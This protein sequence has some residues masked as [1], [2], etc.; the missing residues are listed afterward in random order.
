MGGLG[1]DDKHYSD[2]YR[3]GFGCSVLHSAAQLDTEKSARMDRE[4]FRLIASR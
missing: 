3:T 1:D 2:D 4:Q